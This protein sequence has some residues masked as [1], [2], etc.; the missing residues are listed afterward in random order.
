MRRKALALGAKLLDMARRARWRATVRY[1]PRCRLPDAPPL[2][3]I[4]LSYQRPE[5]MADLARGLLRCDFVGHVIVSNSCPDSDIGD[6]IGF[7]DPRLEIKNA[8]EHTPA[9]YRFELARIAE[10]EHYLCV[11]DD[12][13]LYPKQVRALYARY[14]EDPSVP[15]GLFGYINSFDDSG[16]LQRDMRRR[17]EA[18]VDVLHQVYVLSR[19]HVKE[20]FRLLGELGYTNLKEL[21]LGDDI[22][23]GY[24]SDGWPRCHDVGPILLCPTA[25]DPKRATWKQPGFADTRLELL[26]RIRELYPAARPPP[27][28]VVDANIDR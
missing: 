6:W 20:Y 12:V 24:S 2:T 4:L 27:R 26:V 13:F 22:V 8:G 11:D 9:G 17:V 10:A 5:N 28:E 19:Q 18:S 14:L 1:G 7:I 25:H 21:R 16:N 3:C 15:H 23:L